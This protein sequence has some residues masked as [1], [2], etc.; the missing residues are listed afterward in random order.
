MNRAP[1][2]SSNI[3]S[4]GYDP[5]R[6]LLEVEFSSGGVYQYEDVSKEEFNALMHA[7][8][9]GGHF[10]IHIRNSFKTKRVERE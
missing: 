9:I 6:R 5:A 7:D 8:S 10:H 2:K 3:K 1:V 4:V